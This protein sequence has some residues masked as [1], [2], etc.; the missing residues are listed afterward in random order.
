M[1]ERRY[2][3]NLRKAENERSLMAFVAGLTRIILN[4]FTTSER[5]SR[6]HKEMLRMYSRIF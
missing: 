4:S 5:I 2:V 3:F 1:V 6:S